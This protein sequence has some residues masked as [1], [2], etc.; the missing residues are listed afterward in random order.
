[1]ITDPYFKVILNRNASAPLPQTAIWQSQHV[2]VAESALDAVLPSESR[3][4]EIV[5]QYQ[6][7]SK[8]PHVSVLDQAFVS[9]YC[10]G[11]PHSTMT[12]IRTHAS[13]G[14]KVL[15]QSGRYT[16]KRFVKVADGELPI[17]QAIFFSPVGTYQDR[18]GNKY[19]YTESERQRDIEHALE[20][21]KRFA[22]KLKNGCP[23]ELARE[24]FPYEFRQAF[25][26][27]GTVRS[28]FHM[29]SYRS[30][31]DAE[32]W[33]QVLSAMV[34]DELDVYCPEIAKWFRDNYYI[35]GM[36]GV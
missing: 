9:F 26:F 28:M 36:T 5:V 34:M 7:N 30:K 21:C 12:Q 20:A 32:I 31:K 11:F 1:M 18:Q 24:G 13:S 17:E 2:C 4:G 27:A 23:N 33:C 25:V 35:K 29:L 19:F 3:C 10:E 14:L 16:G 8:A 22:V 15:A 6:L